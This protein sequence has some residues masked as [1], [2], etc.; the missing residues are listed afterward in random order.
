MVGPSLWGDGGVA[1]EEVVHMGQEVPSSAQEV[2]LHTAPPIE[3][4]LYI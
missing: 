1:Q 2:A 4:P 3:L